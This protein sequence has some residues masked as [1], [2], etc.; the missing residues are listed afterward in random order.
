MNV[1]YH[2]NVQK[3]VT[4]PGNKNPMKTLVL[5]GVKSGKSRYAENL[6]VESGKPVTVVATAIAGDA[7]MSQ[8]IEKHRAARPSHWRVLEVPLALTDALQSLDKE[9]ETTNCHV[10]V[11][12]LTLWI[13]QLLCSDYSEQQIQNEIE[14]LVQ[15][16]KQLQSDITIVS[17][18]TGMGIMPVDELSR[19]FGDITGVLH[20]RLAQEVRSVVLM[21]AGLPVTVK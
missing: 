16:V 5:G 1:R 4:L 11:D 15:Q 13:T 17:N 10:I 2:Y 18:E 19:R 3:Q 8:R 12:C 6:A 20:Q 21:V 14:Q 7:E 9:S